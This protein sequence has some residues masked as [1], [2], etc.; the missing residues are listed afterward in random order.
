M[1]R[2]I[3]VVICMFVAC[4]VSAQQSVIKGGI[5]FNSDFVD[6]KL[7]RLSYPSYEFSFERTLGKKISLSLGYNFA[8][9][10]YTMSNP[11]L[12]TFGYFWGNRRWTN[13][14]HVLIPE[15]RYYAASNDKGLFFQ[16]G[17]PLTYSIEKD[18]FYSPNGI[19]NTY[20][21]SIALSVFAGFGLKYPLSK[22][23]GIEMS[24]SISPS[25]DLLGDVDYGTSGFIKSGVKLFYT[26]KKHSP[27][28]KKV[29]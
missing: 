9:R 7:G 5:N 25:A 18:Y 24:I 12:F 4:R 21:H 3:L 22:N 28:E 27:A 14:D 17:L 6:H 15:F 19:Q 11:E 23:W 29:K 1:T 16:F 13:F 10:D 20:Q 2:K 8:V 26:F